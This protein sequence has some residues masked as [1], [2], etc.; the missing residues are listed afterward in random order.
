MK[1]KTGIP[2][3]RSGQALQSLRDSGYSLA[4]ALG[5]PVDNS[6]EAAANN[7]DLWLLE[8]E[9]ANAKKRVHQIVIADDGRGMDPETLQHYLQLG[10]STRYMSKKTI[11]KYGVGAK[12]AALNFGRRIEVW[13]RTRDNEGW[14]YV[15]F[16]LDEALAQEENGEEIFIEEPNQS[17]GPPELAAFF[18]K[19]SGTVVVW[20]KVDRLE[21][22]R[23][24][25]DA[26]KLR[27]EVEKELSRIFRYFLS[28]GIRIAVNGTDLLPHDPLL[29]MEGTWADKVIEESLDGGKSE[30]KGKAKT[31]RPDHHYPGTVLGD[32]TIEVGDAQARLR[33]TLYPKEVT[34]KRGLGGDKF[35]KALRVPE[36]WGAISFIRLDREINYTNVP[37]LFPG[38]VEWQDRFVGIEVSFTPDHDEFFGVRNVK[39]GVEPHEEFRAEMSKRLKKLLQAARTQLEERWG[40][41]QREDHDKDGEHAPVVEAAAEANRTLPKPRVKGPAPDE[42]KRILDDLATDV[43]RTNDAEKQV[44]LDRIKDQPFVVESVDFPGTNFI[45][46][47]HLNDKVIIRL[48]TRHRF[49]RE[50][51]EP[52]NEIAQR[53]A[54]AISPEQAVQAAKRT[55]EALTLLLIAYGKAESMHEDPQER[56]GEL[57]SYWGQFLDSLMGKVKNIK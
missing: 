10:F 47:Q 43:G 49:Y 19:G 46:L 21:E 4:A 53:S 30:G 2:V 34:R 45:D 15:R 20:S 1:T 37:R 27:V 13:S 22:G 16:D 29:L 52:V 33:V 8:E 50:L 38:G 9:G 7:I 24:A 25:A 31:T 39:R 44:Y 3:I 6:L 11:G 14:L 42:E 28:G 48:N 56:Y 17:T 5:E 26:N 51:W 36:N 41:L 35:A 54:G 40:A 18:P 23:R 55:I 32:E 12:L 57:R